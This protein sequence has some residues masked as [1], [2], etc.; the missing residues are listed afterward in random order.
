MTC[1]P[2][3]AAFDDPIGE[4]TG[5]GVILTQCKTAFRRRDVN[6]RYS[7]GAPCAME[8][9]GAKAIIKSR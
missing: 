2:Q 7:F 5:L 3:P 4:A 6:A 8:P 9:V 1:L